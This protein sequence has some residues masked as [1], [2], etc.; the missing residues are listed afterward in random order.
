MTVLLLL[1]CAPGKVDLGP[2][3]DGLDETTPTP[4]A[5]DALCPSTA[6]PAEEIALW[7]AE[8]PELR[9]VR[10]DGSVEPAWTFFADRGEG[11]VSV[12]AVAA[13]DRIVATGLWFAGDWPEIAV[14]T[15][16]VAFDRSG[17]V[18]WTRREDEVYSAAVHLGADGTV[19]WDRGYRS[20]DA[21]NEHLPGE[22]HAPDG[23]SAGLDGWPVGTPL[24]GAVPTCDGEWCGWSDTAGAPLGELRPDLDAGRAVVGDRLLEVSLLGRTVGLLAETR[25]ESV[26]LPLDGAARLDDVRIL[27]VE[28][29]YALVRAVDHLWRFEASTATLVEVDPVLPEGLRPFEAAEYC[30]ALPPSLTADGD[31]LLALRD[32]ATGAL[33]RTDPA[34]SR[35]EQVGAPVTDVL[36]L[37][38]EAV[39]ETTVVSAVSW[40]E[41]YCPELPWDEA[42]AHEGSWTQLVRG[43]VVV[44]IDSSI[45]PAW[46]TVDLSADGACALLPA[47]DVPTVFDVETGGSVALEAWGG[48]LL[49]R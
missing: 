28:G 36:W 13:G 1:A 14:A 33:W 12:S 11:S 47:G 38:G 34:G 7:T 18:L 25:D 9:F 24:D 17:A 2:G 37:S 46:G 32:D 30:E 45:L 6:G 10:M 23:S 8:G 5:Y 49:E 44:P 15:E 48:W 40:L 43:E 19:A 16:L 31:L 39:G 4:P 27:D 35:W 21:S 20:F 42:E 3:P 26:F 29:E 41:T 22:V